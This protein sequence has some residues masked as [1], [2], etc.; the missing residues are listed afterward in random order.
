MYLN[1]L[2]AFVQVVS[3]FVIVLTFID[4]ILTTELT[5]S[6]TSLFAMLISYVGTL[7]ITMFV[8]VYN[9]KSVTAMVPGLILFTFFILTWFPINIVSIFKKNVKWNHIGHNKS[10]NI[11]ELIKN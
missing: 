11:D 6:I 4:K 7:L 10:I 3:L 9:K 2:A 8:T 5:F 1:N